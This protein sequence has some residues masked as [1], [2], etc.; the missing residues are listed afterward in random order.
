[1]GFLQH[2][3]GAVTTVVLAALGSRCWRSVSDGVQLVGIIEMGE[4]FFPVSYKGNH[5]NNKSF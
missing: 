1:M 4:T 2:F 5:K 3:F